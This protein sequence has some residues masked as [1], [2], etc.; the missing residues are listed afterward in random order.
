MANAL[1]PRT[2]FLA[3][4]LLGVVSAPLLAQPGGGRRGPS[5][6]IRNARVVTMAGPVI[7]GAT[8][9]F[10]GGSIRQIGTDVNIPDN[11]TVIDASGMTVTP[12]LID[13]D[14]T[15]AM[16]YAERSANPS[17]TDRAFDSF[18]RYATRL[19]K[20]AV[21]N[22]VTAVY[23]APRTGSG[24]TG[25]GAVVR[26]QPGE[27]PFAGVAVKEDAALCIDLSST[28]SATQRLD[29]FDRVRRQFRSAL[30][31]REATETYKED[32]E[33]YEKKIKERAEK[34]AKEPKKDG[35]AAG[36]EKKEPP[37]PGTTP[38]AGGEKKEDE[39]KKPTEPSPD[40]KSEVLLRAIDREIPVRVRCER[41]EDIYNALELAGEF[42]FDLVIEGATEAY[43][44]APQIAQA[45][46]GVVL[47]SALGRGSFRNDAYQR[48][49]TGGV[50]V[51]SRAGVKWVVGTGRGP[52]GGL[53]EPSPSR[54]VLANAQLVAQHSDESIDALKMV[55]ADAA[56][57]LG[58]SDRVGRLRTGMAAD[59][60]IWSGDPLGAE[61]RVSQ[62][63]V[64]GEL[65][66]R[67][68]VTKAQGGSR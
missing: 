68:D 36:D 56:D 54:F 60:V 61:A 25:L 50:D 3:T 48:R 58:V 24:V 29:I 64:G 37:K 40:R 43:L 53:G 10:S 63:F 41:S 23:V 18:D 12:G 38:A 4:C 26:L 5:T 13:A 11:A 45:K 1:I 44:A 42:S 28:A 15:L 20:D 55:T 8:I 16:S 21:R 14:A 66:Y 52:G 17:P 59:L 65:V 57:F 2:A 9:Q 51:L 6:Y 49:N 46:A 39:I 32:L 27:G 19:F 35:A 33:E 22:G 34:E 67:E 62:V 47:G 31:Y 7:E 30:D